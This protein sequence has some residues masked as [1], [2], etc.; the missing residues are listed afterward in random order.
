ML[1]QL[2]S[3]V[4]E[5]EGLARHLHFSANGVTARGLGE[6]SAANEAGNPVL[7]AVPLLFA[8][9]LD[10]T[11]PHRI[12]PSNYFLQG[13]G[14]HLPPSLPPKPGIPSALVQRIPFYQSFWPRLQQLALTIT[15]G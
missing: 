2:T 3:R 15:E 9:P 12:Y 5:P 10:P 6:E 13:L 7:C 8:P 11:I 14:P 1:F 4:A